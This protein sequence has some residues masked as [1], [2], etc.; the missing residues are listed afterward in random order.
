MAKQVSNV[1]GHDQRGRPQCPERKLG[2]GIAGAEKCE[3]EKASELKRDRQWIGRK[4]RG[5]LCHE[6]IRVHPSVATRV[7]G[8]LQGSH[9]LDDVSRALTQALARSLGGEV[10]RRF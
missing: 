5:S 7:I 3:A 4:A 9:V 2:S 1:G 6:E 10:P 8:W